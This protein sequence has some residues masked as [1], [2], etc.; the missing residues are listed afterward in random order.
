[1]HILFQCIYQTVSFIFHATP[2]IEIMCCNTY[3]FILDG[4]NVMNTSFLNTF[5]LYTIDLII[6]CCLLISYY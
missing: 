5:T 6:V 4:A 1:M 3:I 2:L